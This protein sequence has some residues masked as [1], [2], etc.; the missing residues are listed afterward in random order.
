MHGPGLY[1]T[2]CGN[3]KIVTD[4]TLE[5]LQKNCPLTNGETIRTLKDMLSAID[6]LFEYYFLELKVHNTKD[7]EKQTLDAIAT[8][9]ELH[10]EDKVIFIS[11]DENAK[12]ILG[13]AT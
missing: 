5:Y 6:G 2:N 1:S 9:K 7:T 10:M 11:Y 4:Y 12:T 3:K 8:V 13:N